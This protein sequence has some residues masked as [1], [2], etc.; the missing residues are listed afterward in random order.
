MIVKNLKDIQSFIAGD[1]SIL[2]EIL[3]PKNDDIKQDF[4]LAYAVVK[5]GEKTIPHR[6][7]NSVEVYFILKG[8]GI[9]HIDKEKRRVN[10]FDAIYIPPNSIQW[11]ENIGNED[12]EFICIVSPPWS[13]NNEEILI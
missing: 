6:L 7:K 4:S 13:K 12:L 1:K 5:V 8:S 9:M 2:K 3:H 11:I 10:Q